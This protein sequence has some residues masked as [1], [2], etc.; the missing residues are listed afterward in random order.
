MVGTRTHTWTH[1]HTQGRGRGQT[2]QSINKQPLSRAGELAGT[3]EHICP[4]PPFT[5]LEQQQLSALTVCVCVH[6][7]MCVFYSGEKGKRTV[8]NYMST[9]WYRENEEKQGRILHHYCRPRISWRRIKLKPW[10][11]KQNVVV[12]STLHCDGIA[13][14]CCSSVLLHRGDL[15]VFLYSFFYFLFLF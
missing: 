13:A 11:G 1:T 5:K 4:H 10:A 2:V 12:T 3:F 9:T 15:T 8:K 7:C 6:E 14:H